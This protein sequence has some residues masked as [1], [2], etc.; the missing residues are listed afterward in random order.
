MS[1]KAPRLV[2][3]KQRWQMYF[4]L[5]PLVM[6]YVIFRY[7]PMGGLVICFQDYNIFKGIL[8]SPWVGFDNFSKLFRSSDF[9]TIFRNTLEISLLKIAFGFPA[10]I[11]LALMLNEIRSVHYKRICQNIYYLPHFMSWVIIAGLCFDVFS[12][13]GVINQ[14]VQFFGGEPIFFMSN[15][16]W[17]RVIL[18]VSDIWKEVGWGSIIYLAALAGVD[19]QLYEA[20]S[21]DGA[22][23]YQQVIHVTLPSILS[24][25]AIM[26]VLRMAGILDAGQ[27]Q[28]LMMQNPLV[29]ASSEIIDTFV[30][31][32]GLEKAKY[33]YSTAVGLFKSV[34]AL[35]LVMVSESLRRKA[36]EL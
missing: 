18:V 14:V 22:S 3:Y 13:N 26:F 12:L 6:L 35:G 28:I 24:T 29:R 31:K 10:P 16:H 8:G 32:Q 4:M 19:M 15:P 33:S 30:Y 17:F 25:V 20:A 21:L 5:L 23:R 2:Y 27:D 34:I 1:K 7:I 9:I 11:L 36:E